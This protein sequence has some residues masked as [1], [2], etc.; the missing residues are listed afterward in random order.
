M[1][2][3]E[4]VEKNY[5]LSPNEKYLYGLILQ[6]TETDGICYCSNPYQFFAASF[7]RNTGVSERT[8]RRYIKNLANERLIGFTNNLKVKNAIYVVH[9]EDL[10]HSDIQ[11]LKKNKA[12]ADIVSTIDKFVK[13]FDKTTQNES[14]DTPIL[15]LILNLF[16][17]VLVSKENKNILNNSAGARV[18]SVSKNLNKF[19]NYEQAGKPERVRHFDFESR[20][21]YMQVLFKDFF[22]YH[23]AGPTFDDG[24]VVIDTM[25]EAY[26]QSKTT[27]GFVFNHKTYHESDMLD[28]YFN[29]TPEEFG[30]IVNNVTYKADIRARSCYIMGAILQAGSKVEW[31]K[32]SQLVSAGYPWDTFV[33]GQQPLKNIV[34]NTQQR[35]QRE[36]EQQAVA[37]EFASVI[38][39]ESRS[40][41]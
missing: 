30:S 15:N 5:N 24:K 10:Q 27:R 25:L 18:N 33:P 29:I 1:F 4:R 21:P 28:L 32:T 38:P 9:E 36:K 13:N 31:K 40:K 12:V 26:N 3:P 8:V 6:N 16:N 22:Q 19:A 20:K 37:K 14:V 41:L 39:N 35:L 17:L 2:I 23:P 11:N 34:F 7:G